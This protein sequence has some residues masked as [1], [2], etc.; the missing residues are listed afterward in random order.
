M[1]KLVKLFKELE[2]ELLI[3]VKCGTCQAV[4]P[5]YNVTLEE[6]DVARGKL[7][8][9]DGLIKN[10]FSEPDKV[11]QKINKCL[12]CGSC[13]SSCPSNV[14]IV[15]IFI[16]ARIILTGYSNLS[17]FKK[18]IFRG[19]ISK[20]E[21]FNKVISFFE[22]FQPLIFKSNKNAQQT[23]SLRLISSIVSSRNFKKIAKQ[24]FH[25]TAY[26][27]SSKSKKTSSELLFSQVV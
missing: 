27:K 12:I 1:K 4:C 8:L 18:I 25:K 26:A 6:A 11:H 17:L 23:S 20:P 3:C 21:R 15:G 16:K 13:A 24:P 10:Q 22:K 14:N 5:L 2:Q 9:L 7:A 19:L